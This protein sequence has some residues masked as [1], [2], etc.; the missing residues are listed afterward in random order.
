MNYKSNL[1]EGTQESTNYFRSLFIY[2]IIR[3][4]QEY[5]NR[6]NTVLR[7]AARLILDLPRVCHIR[8][9]MRQDLHW[10]EF[11]NHVTFELSTLAFR[12][13]HGTSP[14]YLARCCVPSGRPNLRSSTSDLLVIPP[15]KTV[16]CGSRAFAVACP[17]GT[18]FHATFELLKSVFLFSGRD[19]RRS[20]SQYRPNLAALL[21][22]II[23][24]FLRQPCS[25]MI[26]KAR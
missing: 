7:A 24:W 1:D 22:V 15:F 12:C 17:C 6:L 10:L 5:L 3:I 23:N 21:T 8:D 18:L 26:I 2:F 25:V 16:W 14:E 4:S 9:I 13:L 19:S 11:P 20:Y